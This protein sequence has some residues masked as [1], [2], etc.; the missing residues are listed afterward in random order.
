MGW[1]EEKKEGRKGRME[2]VG[3]E[4][5]GERDRKEGKSSKEI[6]SKKIFFCT[7]LVFIF[8]AF[9]EI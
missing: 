5:E 3:K 2:G 9:P 8:Y 6:K 4:E 1:K 7:T